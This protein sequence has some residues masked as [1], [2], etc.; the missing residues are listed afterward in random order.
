MG[1]HQERDDLM[2]LVDRACHRG[3]HLVVVV[4]V[5]LDRTEQLAPLERYILAVVLG[6]DAVLVRAEE[7]VTIAHH[8]PGEGVSEG[9][10]REQIE[11]A[12]AGQPGCSLSHRETPVYVMAFDLL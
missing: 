7:H 5:Q 8:D 3:R 1:V 11:Q 12:G 6:L 2:D 10:T 4:G 9:Q